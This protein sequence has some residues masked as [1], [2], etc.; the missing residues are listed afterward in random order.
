[1]ENASAP[2]ERPPLEE[3]GEIPTEPESPTPP[4]IPSLS[5]RR[6]SAQL[7]TPLRLSEKTNTG[8]CTPEEIQQ[9]QVVGA[10][11]YTEFLE[12]RLQ[13]EGITNM[14]VIQTVERHTMTV[15]AAISESSGS[16]ETLPE[17]PDS[18][19]LWRDK[20]KKLHAIAVA[21][22]QSEERKKVRQEAQR[23]VED[24]AEVTQEH[25]LQLME[26]FFQDGSV[27]SHRIIVLF[28]FC[29]DVIV[30]AVKKLAKELFTKFLDWAIDYIINKVCAWV[31]ENGGWDKVLSE[32]W[33]YLGAAAKFL[34][35]GVVIY[36]GYKLIK[37]GVS[38][39]PKK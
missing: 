1:M 4:D 21:F 17:N 37:S 39:L 12:L 18:L 3:E 38:S 8:V 25:F 9:A 29:S 22:E 33:K 2:E 20:G 6:K 24:E 11:V 28:T 36:L 16:F 32:P 5:K 30:F 27:T 14:E 34:L 26:G 13:A 23:V 19:S 31:A 10:A 15:T 7:L 35:A